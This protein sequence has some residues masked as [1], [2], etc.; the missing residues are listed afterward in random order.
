MSE[1]TLRDEFVELYESERNELNDELFSFSR[2]MEHKE[3]MRLLLVM[4]QLMMNQWVDGY[5]RGLETYGFGKNEFLM[6]RMMDNLKQR[7]EE[8]DGR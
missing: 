7:K 2:Q 6:R 3:Y 5:V 8:R 1:M 4:N